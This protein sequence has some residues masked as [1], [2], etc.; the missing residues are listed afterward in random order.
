MHLVLTVM[1]PNYMLNV[2]MVHYYCTLPLSI[3]NCPSRYCS[4]VWSHVLQTDKY[5]WPG[6][7]LDV[8]VSDATQQ[9]LL[10]IL[11]GD[12]PMPLSSSRSRGATRDMSAEWSNSGIGIGMQLPDNDN[13]IMSSMIDGYNGGYHSLCHHVDVM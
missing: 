9:R 8:R 13:D 6:A 12:A 2:F 3:T 7:E 1:K 10:A 5:I 4:R 11:Q